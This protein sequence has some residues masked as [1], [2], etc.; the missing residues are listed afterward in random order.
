MYEPLCSWFQNDVKAPLLNKDILLVQFCFPS[1]AL[2]ISISSSLR[3]VHPSDF[4]FQNLNITYSVILIFL[5]FTSSENLRGTFFI[6]TPASLFEKRKLKHW[7]LGLQQ[8]I[9][10]FI[11]NIYSNHHCGSSFKNIV[12][13]ID[14]HG[15][16]CGSI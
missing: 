15:F 10:Q 6:P 7:A 16:S 5:I 9:Q 13:L 2:L 4:S 12:L 3:L 1:S 11:N 8:I 14:F